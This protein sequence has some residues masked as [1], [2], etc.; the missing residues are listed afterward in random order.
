MKY[1]I[2]FSILILT[3]CENS[4]TLSVDELLTALGG[5][6]FRVRL[7][8]KLDPELD[9]IGLATRRSDSKVNKLMG[10]NGYSGGEIV[11]II[12]FKRPDERPRFSLINPGGG[13]SNG[14]LPIEASSSS[15]ADTNVIHSLGDRLI[16]F[17]EDNELSHST[18]PKGDDVDLILHTY[19]SKR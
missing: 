12:Y 16:R 19:K 3:S 13:S 11:T 7:P 9:Y 4:N 18:I 17:S 1:L 8:E 2:L 10:G 15:Y 5:N 14:I 6:S